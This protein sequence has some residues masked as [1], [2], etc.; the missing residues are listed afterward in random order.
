MNLHAS[1]YKDPQGGF[2]GHTVNK[3]VIPICISIAFLIN[4]PL[5]PFRLVRLVGWGLFVCLSGGRH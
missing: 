5:K 2:Q 4:N 3:K 1:R